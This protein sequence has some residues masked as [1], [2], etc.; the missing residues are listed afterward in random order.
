MALPTNSEELQFVSE[1]LIKNE[2][3]S[4]HLVNYSKELEEKKTKLQKQIR[5]QKLK[6]KDEGHL[7]WLAQKNPTVQELIP[8]LL[9][10]DTWSNEMKGEWKMIVN[11][12]QGFANVYYPYWP[13]DLHDKRAILIEIDTNV[14]F[15]CHTLFDSR[16]DVPKKVMVNNS[17]R[18]DLKTGDVM[19]HNN[20]HVLF[21][22]YEIVPS[23]IIF[24]SLSGWN[25]HKKNK[26][27]NF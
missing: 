9:R 25:V 12:E 24:C 23:E 1:Q 16:K 27:I 2:S 11:E 19:Q 15:R 22:L 17:N 3:V 13:E 18:I 4:K 6:E 20:D 8:V 10:D 26:I 14:P 5:A 21:N 7:Q